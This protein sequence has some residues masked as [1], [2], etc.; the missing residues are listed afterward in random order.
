[1]N[2]DLLIP[3]SAKLKFDGLMGEIKIA[4]GFFTIFTL[5]LFLDFS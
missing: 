3:I 5:L 4:L 2:M 1:M